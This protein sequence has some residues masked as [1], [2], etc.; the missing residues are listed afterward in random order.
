M[1]IKD[2]GVEIWMNLYENNCTY[3]LAET[4]VNS[5]T[6]SEILEI[7]G[8]KDSFYDKMGA[9]KLTYGDIEG[10][11]A[12][13]DAI[14][15]LYTC[16]KRSNIAVTH[17]TIGANALSIMTLVDSGDK[18]ISVLPTYQQ[19][20]SI[21]ESIG[22]DVHILQLQQKNNWMP[23][24]DKLRAMA[25]KGTKLICINNPN[26]PTGAVMDENT[27]LAIVDIARKCG[28]YLLCD[29]AYRGLTHDAKAPF[30]PSVVDLY[31]KG[32]STAGM[33][34]TFSA[35]GLRLG[36]IAGP[37]DF[38]ENINR[39][40]DY[41]VISVGM[42]NDALATL[43]LQNK[44]KII[45]RNMDI[46]LGNAKML[47]DWVASEPLIS[48][49][50]PKGGTTAFLKYDIDMPSK[51][52]CLKLLEQTGVLVLPGSAFDIEGY[53]RMGYCN[54]P[55]IIRDGLV[56]FSEFLRQFSK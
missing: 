12:L 3:N 8:Q 32:I 21:P 18:I 23:D 50:A 46:V 37:V 26:N 10:S 28:A 15:S 51:D 25:T 54:D 43:I 13:R 48:Y 52:F 9:M 55:K 2:F 27:L 4:C 29:E 17:G 16:Q 24:L 30:T 56:K 35:A 31:E 34:K 11:D 6:V 5:L 39:Q 14:C 47:A 38:I 36:W 7:S 40:R 19:H 33:S 41:H 42:I 1:K 22:A 45:A 20:Y 49:T 53:F 44:D